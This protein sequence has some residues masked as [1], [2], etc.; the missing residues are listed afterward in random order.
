MKEIYSRSHLT[1]TFR[2]SLGVESCRFGNIAFDM[3]F[4]K[5]LLVLPRS[6][7]MEKKWKKKVRN[8]PK[9]HFEPQNH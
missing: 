2:K 1:S 3:R 9:S 4:A 8:E 5:P 7:K 6:L